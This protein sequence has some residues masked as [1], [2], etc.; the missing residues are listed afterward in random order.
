[1]ENQQEVMQEA[2]QS[3]E[4]AEAVQAAAESAQP[5]AAAHPRA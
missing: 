3:T 2:T 1:M 4:V 5:E